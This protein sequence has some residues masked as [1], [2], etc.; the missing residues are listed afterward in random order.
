[1]D[2]VRKTGM[3]IVYSE[4]RC[5]VCC[6]NQP[7]D[8]VYSHFKVC[9]VQEFSC[10]STSHTH[11]GPEVSKLQLSWEL[12]GICGGEKRIKRTR[13][14]RRGGNLHNNDRKPEVQTSWVCA[15]HRQ[16]KHTRSSW[17]EYLVKVWL[18][19]DLKSQESQKQ[20]LI[21]LC[22]VYSPPA[23]NCL[24]FFF[25]LLIGLFVYWLC[26]YQGSATCGFSAAL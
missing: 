11:T 23:F 24:I 1:M 13:R 26:I 5:P 8:T 25:F 6:L 10:C 4:T 3:E 7:S 12:L 19:L 17:L 2:S 15:Q 20:S 9:S 21:S 18:S 22:S 14:G 16:Q